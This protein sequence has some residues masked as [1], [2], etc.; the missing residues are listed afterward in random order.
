MPPA[1]FT[2]DRVLNAGN[3]VQGVPSDPMRICTAFLTS[4][5]FYVI[6]TATFAQSPS[7]IINRVERFVQSTI[8]KAAEAEWK[9]LPQTEFSCVDQKL[10]ERGDSIQTVVKRGVF[11]SDRRVSHIRSQCRSSDQQSTESRYAIDGLT[12]GSRIGLDSAAYREYSC[13][14]SEQ[15]DG[16]TWCQKTRND[17]ERRGSFTATYSL[18]H[19]GDGKIVYVNRYQQPA[20]FDS[21]EADEG[22]QRYSRKIGGP[23]R[24]IEMPHRADPPDGMIALWGTTTLERL[25]QNSTQILSEGKS[26]KKG[27]LIDFIG[28]FARSAKEGL[29]IYRIGG[30][31]GF[32]WVAS[33]DQ[34][35]RGTLRFAAVDASE[36]PN[37]PTEQAAIVA[38]SVPPQFQRLD[39]RAFKRSRQDVIVT[40]PSYNDCEKACSQSTSC[41]ALT[42]FREEKLCRIMQ[43]PTELALDEGADSAI[44]IGSITGSVAPQEPNVTEPAK[45]DATAPPH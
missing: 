8:A 3:N 4:L 2:R 28:N 25:D 30:G 44:R 27:L 16:F 7:D 13:S 9:K 12:V 33:F 39:N 40:A 20:F 26:P 10:Q 23:P 24:I 14:P 41:T 43:S 35:G 38:Q 19:A 17:K 15:F 6:A 29:P 45:R 42:F 22:I 5:P 37:P 36:L 21:N 34:R 18:L 32:I 31:A 11:P 1:W